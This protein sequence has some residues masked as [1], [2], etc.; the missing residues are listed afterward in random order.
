M[1]RKNNKQIFYAFLFDIRNYSPEVINFQRCEAILPR[2][3]NFKIKQ[4]RHGIFYYMA[5]TPDKIWEDKDQQNTT[6]SIKTQVSFVKTE[7]RHIKLQLILNHF[8]LYLLIF[9]SEVISP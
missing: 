5:P 6:I 8:I 4:K 3:N 1:T 7:L 2:V 9:F